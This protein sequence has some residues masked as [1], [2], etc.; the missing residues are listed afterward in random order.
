MTYCI[1]YIMMRELDGRKIF[2][3]SYECSSQQTSYMYDVHTRL[4]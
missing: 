3:S 4:F 1:Q 2:V